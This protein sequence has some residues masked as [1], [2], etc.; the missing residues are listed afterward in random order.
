M[1]QDG[2]DSDAAS[3]SF[4]VAASEQVAFGPG[5]CDSGSH[6]GLSWSSSEEVAQGLGEAERTL[7]SG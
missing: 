2:P 5:R 3:S 1:N 7:G 6:E 4:K